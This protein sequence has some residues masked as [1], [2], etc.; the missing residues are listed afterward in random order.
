M[1]DY[2]KSGKISGELVIDGNLILTGDLEVEKYISVTGYIDCAGYFIEAGSFIKA[3]DSSEWKVVEGMTVDRYTGLKDKNGVEIYEGDIV[4][5]KGKSE[6]INW[7][8]VFDRGCFVLKHTKDGVFSYKEL[9]NKHDFL[10][11]VIGNIFDN[12]ELLK[13]SK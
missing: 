12:P 6:K 3:G 1:K 11:E 5:V 13:E 10:L 4:R 2:K 9:W 8:I 7:E